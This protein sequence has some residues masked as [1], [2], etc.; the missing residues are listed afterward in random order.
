VHVQ[1]GAKKSD[2]AGLH[3]DALKVRIAAPPADNKANLELI[4]LLSRLLNVPQAAIAIRR[5]ATG[6]RKIIEVAGGP[7]LAARVYSL[8]TTRVTGHQSRVTSSRPR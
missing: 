8:A 1:P 6:R 4:R 2:V 5:G 7:E 3:G